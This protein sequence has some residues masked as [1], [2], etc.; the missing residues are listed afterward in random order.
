[1]STRPIL[2][3]PLRL[4]SLEFKN[5]I[6]V[7]LMCQYSC[8]DGFVTDWHLVHLGARAVGGAALIVM[9][10]TAVEARGRISPADAGIWKDEHTTPLSRIPAF[11]WENG[12]IAAIQLAHAG[13]KASTRPTWKG[14][15]V[16]PPGAEDGWL[17]VAPSPIPF[18]EGDPA[19]AELSIPEIRDTVEAFARAARRVLEAG[20]QVAEIHG[21]HGYLIHQFLSPLSNRRTDV[22][23]G[24]FE[25]RIRLVCE[26]TEAVRAV[27]PADLPLFVRLSATDWVEGGWDLDQTVALSKILRDLGVDLIDC[28][29]GGAAPRVRIPVGPGYQVPFAERVRHEAGIETGAVGLITE[30]AQA[31]QIVASGQAGM[32][33]LARAMLRDPFWAHNAARA[34]GLK[35]V[36][37]VQYGRAF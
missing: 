1:M 13:R 18:E 31:E 22:Y 4:R 28:S 27:W 3:T 34:L 21:A 19:P 2:F 9:E 17:P 33:L 32:V 6:A 5:R 20:F 7:S 23:G 24:S 10:A 25:N 37:P 8:R 14:G 11:I 16:L 12:A 29:S 26:V 15:G 30:P 36:P 35:P